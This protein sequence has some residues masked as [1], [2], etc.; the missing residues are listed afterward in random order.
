MRVK[1]LFA[2]VSF[3]DVM[4]VRGT[5]PAGQP[6]FPLVPGYDAVAQV[7]ALPPNTSDNVPFAVGD[8][9]A[10]SCMAGAW[11]EYM[12]VPIGAQDFKVVVLNANKA[13]GIDGAKVC[14]LVLNYMTAFQ[15]LTRI[16]PLAPGQRVLVHGVSGGVGSALAELA[17]LTMGL[18]VYGTC[19]GRKMEAVRTTAWGAKISLIDYAKEDFVEV[20]RKVGG[21]DAVFDAVGGSNFKR[22]YR[23]LRAG[24][25]FVAYGVTVREDAHGGTSMV[26]TLLAFAPFF[27]L[28]LRQP[29]SGLRAI[30][31]FKVNDVRMAHPDWFRDDFAR[32]LDMLVQGTIDPVIHPHRFTIDEAPQ[33]LQ[34]VVDGGVVG[35]A[36]IALLKKK[37]SN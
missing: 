19:S 8:L 14:A 10:I 29:F 7:D 17:V 31:I 23:S 12:L 24:G 30:E 9:V 16:Q 36:V 37:K 1:V 35:K 21:V 5:Y 27:L 2:G 32:L 34:L 25:V 11:Q 13:K 6:P 4:I 15:M 22:S 3:P 26:R 28:K 18:E 20:V 33:A